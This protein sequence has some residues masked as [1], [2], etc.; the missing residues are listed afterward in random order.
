MAAATG[1]K[2]DPAVIRPTS[3]VTDVGEFERAQHLLT[4]RFGAYNI[5]PLDTAHDFRLV[6]SNIATDALEVTRVLY[7]SPV[8]ING[9]LPDDNTFCIGTAVSGVV[10]LT[11]AG[12]SVELAGDR[13]L[14]WDQRVMTR[15]RRTGPSELVMVRLNIPTF[16]RVVADVLGPTDPSARFELASPTDAVDRIRWQATVGMVE[17]VLGAATQEPPSALLVDG[18]TRYVVTAL[19]DTHPNSFLDTLP[20]ADT[21]TVSARAARLAA[22]YLREHHADP[23]RVSDLASSLHLTTRALQSGFLRTYGTTM[24][25]YLRQLRLESA[26]EE[27]VADPY[28]TVTSLAYRWG[29][30][31]PSRFAAAYRERYGVTPALVAAQRR[32]TAA[33]S[34]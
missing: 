8:E 19:L 2:G 29:F 4:S 30:S 21:A 31:S 23:I 3:H 9:E 26:H 11:H 18:L 16:R 14:L 10:E 7:G 33:A 32:T 25:D 6:A 20:R 12:R 34:G 28:A 24:R 27:L 15:T 1:A 17:Q 22:D 13:S 5:V